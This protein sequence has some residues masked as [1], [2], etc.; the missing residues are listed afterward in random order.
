MVLR[1]LCSSIII[2]PWGLCL[3]FF[4]C[5]QLPRWPICRVSFYVSSFSR[6]VLCFLG[7][8]FMS[9][10]FPSWWHPYPWPYPCYLPHF[11]SFC[12]PVGLCGVNC[13]TSQ[14]F[15]LDF[16]LFT[17][18]VHPPCWILW[19]PWWHQDPWCPFWFC[20]FCIFFFVKKSRRRS[21]PCKC[22]PKTKE[23]LGGFWYPFLMFHKEAF[24]STFSR[25]LELNWCFW[26]SFYEIFKKTI[27]F[28][29]IGVP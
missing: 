23:R 16:V 11:L 28:R 22:V 20:L 2:I 4:F 17:S 6:F 5:G 21:S 3:S 14:I 7:F 24:L 15:S 1:F 29:F 8:L 10:P 26:F 9:L 12:F 19:P 25:F 18:W 13:S 27:G